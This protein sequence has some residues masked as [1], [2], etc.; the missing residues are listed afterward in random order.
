MGV[1]LE[2]L[3]ARAAELDLKADSR[4]ETKLSVALGNATLESVLQAVSRATGVPLGAGQT[5]DDWLAREL[6]VNVFVKDR[7]AYKVLEELAKLTDF[8]WS[9]VGEGEKRGYRL[10]QDQK[11]RQKQYEIRDTAM[12]AER[13][14]RTRKGLSN[15]E[16]MSRIAKATPQQLEELSKTDPTAF[17]YATQPGF[18]SIPKVLSSLDRDQQMR[19]TTTEGIRLPYKSLSPDL[20]AAAREYVSGMQDLVRKLAPQVKDMTLPDPEWDKTFIEIKAPSYEA[21]GPMRDLNPSTAEFG[22]TGAGPLTEALKMPVLDT[23]SPMGK[24]VGKLFSDMTQGVPLMNLQVAMSEEFG[25][26]VAK[27]WGAPPEEPKDPDLTKKIKFEV[28]GWAT[29]DKQIEAFHQASGLEVISD[30]LPQ[31]GM[32]GPSLAQSVG[33]EAPVYLVLHRFK[34]LF[35]L[36]WTKEGSLV[37]MRD[38]S[39]AKKRDWLI[40][41]AMSARWREHATSDAG[42]TL[43]DLSEM[44]GLTEAQSKYGLLADPALLVYS[45]LLNEQTRPMLR[46]LGTLSEDQ[47]K[48]LLA[49]EKLALDTLTADQLA[50]ARA[51]WSAAHRGADDAEVDL[52]NTA[53]LSLTGIPSLTAPG[54]TDASKT[55]PLLKH[56]GAIVR[57]EKADA[58]QTP[59]SEG[60]PKDGP[61]RTSFNLVAVKSPT[62]PGM[63]QE[64]T[65]KS[66]P[67]KPGTPAQPAAK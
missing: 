65:P 50:E 21:L 52:P 35:D 3:P 66:A 44:A 40:P 63:E 18:R 38:Q 31:S 42:P 59:A 43:Q 23:A 39:W 15:I 22:V 8:H 64:P 25:R 5:A 53:K 13:A 6:P 67:A 54:N 29:L 30:C 55:M 33:Q 57:L 51:A 11:G 37:E 47:T 56:Q 32:E 45:V 14:E 17:F 26:M 19:S 36:A 4:F 49:G 41:R 28:K 34:T 27:G 24:V 61:G 2:P 10:W 48:K 20:Q 1:A 46:L 12:Q 58:P 62:L 9:S 60:G 16:A 7:P